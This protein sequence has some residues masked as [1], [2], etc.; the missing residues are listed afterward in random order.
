MYCSDFSNRIEL[1]VYGLLLNM[2]GKTAEEKKNGK[3]TKQELLM[4]PV[5]KAAIAMTVSRTA[6]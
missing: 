3:T 1:D 4:A 2:E 5:N 6:A